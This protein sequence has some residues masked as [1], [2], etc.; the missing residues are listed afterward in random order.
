MEIIENTMKYIVTYILRL[1]LSVFS[2]IFK[3]NS[4]YYHTIYFIML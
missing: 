4:G 3:N 1:S 2:C